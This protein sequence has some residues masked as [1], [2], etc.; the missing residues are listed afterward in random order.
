MNFSFMVEMYKPRMTRIALLTVTI[1]LSALPATATDRASDSPYIIKMGQIEAPLTK[2]PGIPSRGR[3]IVAGRR[4]NCLACH[5]A[6]IPEEQFHGNLGPD[7]SKIGSYYDAGELR[8]RL[9]DPKQL[10][11]DTIMPAF[12]KTTGLNRVGK[13]YTGKPILSAQQIED[14]IAYLLTLKDNDP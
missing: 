12:L 7:L 14:V 4:A 3:Q 2:T 9:V 11:P 1:V 8:L 13:Q 6:P 5:T 10:N